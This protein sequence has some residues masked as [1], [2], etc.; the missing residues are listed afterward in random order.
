MALLE[1]DE[2]DLENLVDL[3][4]RWVLYPLMTVLN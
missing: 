3:E 4:Q 1:E 2:F